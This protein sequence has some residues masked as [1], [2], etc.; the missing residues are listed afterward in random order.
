VIAEQPA[1]QLSIQDKLK[2]GERMYREGI[3]PSGEPMQ[4]I[5]T[6][7][8]T[9]SGT[10]FSCVSCHLRS[11]L[12]SYEGGV[13]T[14]PTNG[15]SLFQPQEL[16]YKSVKLDSKLYP[17][18]IFRKAYTD[19]TL[20]VALRD[21]RDPSDRAFNPVMPR[22]LLRD[23]DVDILAT[24]LKSLS[25]RHASGVT[26]TTISLATVITD[27]AN[28]EDAN[29]MMLALDAFVRQK[30]NM[31]DLYRTNQ[32]SARMAATMLLSS[33][34]MYKKISLVTWKLSGPRD[35][36]RGQLDAYYRTTPVFALLSGI[37]GGDW[38]PI[39]DFC[40]ENRIPSLFPETEY[41]VINET[42]WYTLYFSKGY[43][44]EGESAARYLNRIYDTISEKQVIQ[45][46]RNSP[47]GHTLAHGFEA[48]WSEAGH[49][50][51]KTIQLKQDEQLTSTSVQTELAK[52]PKSI[53]ILWDGS[54]ALDGIK[55]LGS[56]AKRP[57]MIFVSSGYM[58]N[59]YWKI[60]EQA[61]DI[62]YLTYPFRLPQKESYYKNHI[63]AVSKKIDVT[64]HTEDVLKRA[65]SATQ[66][67]N[68]ALMDIRGNY[69]QDN[70]LDVIGMLKDQDFPLYERLSFGPGQRY[71]SKG[72]YIV[73]LGKGSKP[74]LIGRSDWVIH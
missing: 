25:A 45:I 30:N 54:D 67:L 39:H 38:K 71:A 15:P 4:A 49:Q 28:Q 33:E 51:L 66:V 36:W 34:V 46:V 73:Q 10:A 1:S 40:E 48:T 27:D 35:T 42:D 26:D 21:G 44:Q 5:V 3:L 59:D 19:E 62:T 9:V 23:P 68:L 6:R 2:L 7:D 22:Y 50:K 52:H 47:Q 65:Y 57:D 14:P 74:E 24:Y 8:I 18:P 63:G 17:V 20:S 53:I 31:A 64:G 69:Y 56:S 29:A 43:Y 70:L 13:V 12:G 58:G 16:K 37:S 72:C 41:P 61:R 60:H 11:G 55:V 32:R